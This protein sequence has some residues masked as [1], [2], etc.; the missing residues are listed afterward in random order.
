MGE[1][2]QKCYD[3][4]L[5][6]IRRAAADDAFA[7][8]EE[9][10]RCRAKAA[11]DVDAAVERALTQR[12]ELPPVEGLQSWLQACSLGHYAEPAT[13]WCAEMGAANVG[14][15]REHWESFADA[16]KLKPL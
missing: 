1:A 5:Q 7:S 12:G 15:V 9:L 8:A 13:A 11:A 6:A 14:E 4:Q 10:E 3:D 2:L 16:L